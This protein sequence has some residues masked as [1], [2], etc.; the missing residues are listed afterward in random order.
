MGLTLQALVL[1]ASATRVFASCA[2]GTFLSPRAEG[3]TVEVKTFGY[4]GTICPNIGMQGPLNW[5]ALEAPANS[6]CA[7]GTKQ[8]PIDMVD[9]VFTVIPGTDVQITVNDMPDGA[10][11]ENLGTT[12]EV[13]TQG[14]TLDVGGK[15]FE[16]Q[17][18]HF[19]LPSEHLDNGTSQAME[20]HMVWQSAAQELAVIGV[21]I[22]I[23]DAVPPAAPAPAK[24][25]NKILCSRLNRRQEAVPPPP[26]PTTAAA[27]PPTTLLETI[28]SVVDQIAVPGTKVTTPPLAM[29]E[30]VDV[31][32]AGAFQ[33]YD[34][35]LTTPPCS[36]GV[37]WHVST[38]RL[39]V[40]PATLA[41]AR[42]VIGFNSRYPQN[43][44]GQPNILMISAMGSAVAAIVDVAA[45]GA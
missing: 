10:E 36:E 31:L 22:A 43:A 5:A 6:V 13:I 27:V 42:D 16:L 37:A 33:V 29:G 28:F 19:H 4:S 7:T 24:R 12:V 39:G 30:V 14:G 38:A 11:F 18:F 3:G 44:P 2:H 25:D 1:V 40:A 15:Q 20:M 34:G 21:Y 26:P 32:R 9:G 17:Q 45:P 23:A 8:S 41:R 35:S